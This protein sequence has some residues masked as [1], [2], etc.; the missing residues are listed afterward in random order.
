MAVFTPVTPDDAAALA[1]RLDLG[2]LTELRGIQS[3]IENTNYFLTTD[4]GE[5]VLTL[6]ERLTFEQLPF[7]LHLMKHLAQRGIPVPEPKGDASGEILH[8][9]YGKPTAVVDKLRGQ[10][11]LAPDQRHCEQVGAMLARMHLAGRD[12]PRHQPNLRGL[13]WWTETVP[14]VLPYLEPA[15]AELIQDELAFQQALAAS[16]AY[17]QLPR[18]PIHADLFRD[19][20][21]FEGDTLTGFFDFYFA[22]VDTWLFDIAVCLNDWCVDLATGRLDEQRAQAFCNAYDRVRE[23]T[24]DECRLLPAL[25]RAGA[26]RF[27]ISRLWDYHLPRDA[28][29]LKAHDPAHFER[30]LR[31]RRAQPWHY[32]RG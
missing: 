5:Y 7:Y 31:E 19:N 29:M 17:A 1:R 32:L 24:H 9:L 13:A 16:P 18:G 25:M 10:H 8:A 20:V 14:V 27:W 4:R 26:L 15:Q 11:Q 23:I 28:Q 12:Y 21:M 3:G 6:F 30:I 2:T 22:G